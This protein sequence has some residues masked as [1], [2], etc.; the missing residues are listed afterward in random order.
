MVSP[1]NDV[2][3]N[4]QSEQYAI[5]TWKIVFNSVLCVQLFWISFTSRTWCSFCQSKKQNGGRRETFFFTRSNSW[6]ICRVA[7]FLCSALV[8]EWEWPLII[9]LAI[10]P[11]QVLYIH[12]FRPDQPETERHCK[13][14]TIKKLVFAM[15]NHT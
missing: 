14:H 15:A 8:V 12:Q 4:S 3:V 1:F 5:F 7:Q 13:L 10:V 9:V 11:G 2:L 6:C